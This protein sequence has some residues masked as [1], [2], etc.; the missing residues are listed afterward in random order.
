[1]NAH[2][3]PAWPVLNPLDFV[4]PGLQRQLPFPLCAPGRAS[5]YVARNAIYHL[6]RALRFGPGE[7][8]LVPDYHSGNEVWAIRAA[9][10]ALRYYAV[11]RNLEPDLDQ[12]RRLVDHT[13]RALYVIHFI[14]WPQPI[15]RLA[16]FCR[17][18]NIL[19]IEDCALCLLSESGGRPLGSFGDYAV[20]CLY[21]T[22]PVP[23]G[24][25][26]VRN[27]PRAPSLQRIPL[28]RCSPMSVLGRTLELVVNW[29]RTNSEGMGRPV[30]ELKRRLGRFLT[31]GNVRRVPVGDIGFE[32]GN[33]NLGMSPMCEALLH[34]FDYD[35]VV[36][37]RRANY[38]ALH[39]RL[40]GRVP[41]LR[42][43]LEAGVCP[44]FFP[45]LVGDKAAAARRLWNDGIEAT[46]FWNYGDPAA[47]GAA[48]GDAQYLRDRVLELPIH[49][50]VT[51]PQ[52]DH[53]ARRVL[54]LSIHL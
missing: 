36:R 32:L 31:A 20:Y 18:R 43:P 49:Q 38:T 7:S 13:T 44:L 5:F 33:V 50:D 25:V 4:R 29:L 10:A 51:L 46:E 21:K 30:A 45:I 34:H 17:E 6:F 23:N 15:E 9:G 19:L 8:V 14:G 47:A 3:V 42:G 48:A 22:L 52:I 16:E 39:D 28:E 11:D 40:A 41:L 2:F 27:N 37:K 54:D 53:I 1:V 12:I 35:A 26:L 24:G